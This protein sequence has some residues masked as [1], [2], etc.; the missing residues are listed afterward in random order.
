VRASIVIALIAFPA[1]AL[2]RPERPRR[3]SWCAHRRWMAE[4][5][6]DRP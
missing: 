4:R 2:S 1:I 6:R 5:S 3:G